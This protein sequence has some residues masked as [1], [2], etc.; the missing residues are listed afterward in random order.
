[1]STSRFKPLSSDG[2]RRCDWNFRQD[3]LLLDY[4]DREWGVP[5]HDDQKLFEKLILDGAQAGLSWT[6]ILKRREG[7]RRAFRGFDPERVARFTQRDVGRLLADSGIIRNRAKVKS[8]IGNARAFLRIQEEFGSFDAYLWRFVEG[9]PVQNRYRTW[10]EIPATNDVAEALSRDLKRRGFTFVGPTI[11]Y[12]YMQAIGMVNDH[13][14]GCFRHREVARLG[15]RGAKT[16]AR[17]K[18]DEERMG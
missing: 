12:A 8:A 13:T 10:R 3:L 6:T 4:H 17:R 5:E 11:V 14:V 16:G 2:K 15:G 9:R 18:R 7:Y 1:M